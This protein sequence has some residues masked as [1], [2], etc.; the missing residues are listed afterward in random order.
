MLYLPTEKIQIPSPEGFLHIN[1]IVYDS[2]SSFDSSEGLI[3]WLDGWQPDDFDPKKIK[4]DDPR[5]H[6]KIGLEE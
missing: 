1:M 5:V 3:T 2:F 4:F 6:V